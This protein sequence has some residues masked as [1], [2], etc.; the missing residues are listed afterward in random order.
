MSSIPVKND[1]VISIS[2]FL[3]GEEVFEVPNG[4]QVEIIQNWLDMDLDL[5]LSTIV[6]QDEQNTID[7][8]YYFVNRQSHDKVVLKIK[9]NRSDPET[10]TID[11]M[12]NSVF[13]EGELTE[14]LGVKFSGQPVDQVFLPENWDKG[15]PLRKDW[16]DPDNE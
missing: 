4:S 15:Y 6:G 5:H 7:L 13:Y 1:L 12:I 8:Y 16:E 11:H 9:L 10:S 14:M 3:S 2:K